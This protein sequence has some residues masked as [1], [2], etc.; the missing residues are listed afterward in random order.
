MVKPKICILG[1]SIIQ[2]LKTC[3]QKRIVFFSKRIIKYAHN[4][5]LSNINGSISRRVPCPK[6]PLGSQ[7]ATSRKK[8]P[9]FGQVSNTA[10]WLHLCLVTH[11][12]T[13]LSQNVCLIN[14]HIF[15]YWY[16]RCTCK[17]W[18]VPWL[19]CVFEVFSYRIDN[20]SCLNCFISTK[21]SQIMFLINVHV[22]ICQ[23][24]KCDCRL[25]KVLWFN[26]F[27]SRI[28]MLFHFETL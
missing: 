3:F 23:Y 6:D 22:L 17:L 28:F 24:A 25:C 13:K 27:F 21:L 2:N 7:F 4:W 10:L 14:T 18:K 11:I 26:A 19:Y 16:A 20:H 1:F 9:S 8:Y 15:M 5:L 12:L